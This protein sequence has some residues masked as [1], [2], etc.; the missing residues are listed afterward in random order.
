M[1]LPGHV[2][3]GQRLRQPSLDV[4]VLHSTVHTRTSV[5][6]PRSPTPIQSLFFLVLRMAMRVA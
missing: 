1:G 2:R 5:V 4:G 3:L 6:R